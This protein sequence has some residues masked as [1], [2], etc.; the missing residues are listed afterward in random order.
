MNLKKLNPANTTPASRSV[1]RTPRT[2]GGVAALRSLLCVGFAALSLLSSA[3]GAQDGSPTTARPDL[4][5]A[6]ALLQMPVNQANEAIKKYNAKE[7]EILNTQLLSLLRPGNPDVDRVYGLIRHLETL[8][9]DAQAQNRLN[10]LLYVLGLTLLLFSGFLIYVIVDQRRSLIALQ[11]LL[12]SGAE[13]KPDHS[14][15]TVYRGE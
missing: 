6:R 1:P 5:A 14:S 3:A 8:R 15:Q 13:S 2:R 7:A 12:A 11:K 9:A 4:S 10:T